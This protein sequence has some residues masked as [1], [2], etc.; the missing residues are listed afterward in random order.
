VP[1]KSVGEG[2]GGGGAANDEAGGDEKFALEAGFARVF[3]VEAEGFK[4]GSGEVGAGE[5]DR[6][7]RRK[8]ELCEVDVIE[9]DDGE[10]VRNPEALEIGGAED[11]DGGHVIG[12]D[13]SG[14]LA[15]E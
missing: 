15:G 14:W 2:W 7:K 13:D 1:F 6:G 3:G 12:A 9:T 11:A 8:G 5:S 10:V 4:S